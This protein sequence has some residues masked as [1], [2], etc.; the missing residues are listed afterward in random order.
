MWCALSLCAALLTG[1]TAVQF[2][3]NTERA[4]LAVDCEPKDATL[5]IDGDPVGIT[6]RLPPSGIVLKP[7]HHR[8]EITRDGFF[9]YLRDIDAPA[10]RKLT[11]AL[12]MIEKIDRLDDL[13]GPPELLD[14][15]ADASPVPL[16]SEP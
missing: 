4:Y 13:D 1:C 3:D 8:I 15:P 14:R 12:D 10:G 6:G 7:G 9:P 16:P 11:L 5:S 2:V